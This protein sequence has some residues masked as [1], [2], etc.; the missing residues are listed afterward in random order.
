MDINFTQAQLKALSDNGITMDD[1]RN[2]VEAYR[3]Q[4]YSDADIQRGL[5]G[6]IKQIAPNVRTPVELEDYSKRTWDRRVRQMKDLGIEVPEY[7]DSVS[8]T[9][10][11][12]ETSKM[13]NDELTKRGK[14]RDRAIRNLGRAEAAVSAFGSAST[15]G[16]SDLMMAGVDAVAGTD[17][18]EESKTAK[19]EHPGYTIAGTVGGYLNPLGAATYV[20]KGV[21]YLG[22]GAKTIVTGHVAGKG[23]RILGGAA[24]MATNALGAQAV[25]QTQETAQKLAETKEFVSGDE[26]LKEYGRGSA[27]NAAIDAGFQLV[28]GVVGKIGSLAS[29]LRK[30]VDVLGG[31]ANVLKGQAAHK[32]VL[33]HGGTNEEAA[34]AFFGAVMEDL[35]TNKRK[36]FENMLAGNEEFAK[37][38]QQQMAGAG[39]VVE[40]SIKALSNPEYG[41]VSHELLKNLWGETKNEL[42]TYEIDFTKKGLERL[43][44]LDNTQKALEA[45]KEALVRAEKRV[46][47][48]A[49]LADEVRYTFN[50]LRD[51][52]VTNGSRDLERASNMVEQ[53]TLKSFE[54]SKAQADALARAEERIANKTQEAMAAGRE[55]TKSEAD[56]ILMA[57][58]RSGAKQH[59]KETM[60][61]GTDSVMDINDIKEFFAQVDEA[62]V[63]AGQA[64][65]FGAFN[66]GVNKRILDNLDEVLYK[67]N[68]AKRFGDTL[69]KMHDFGRK[70]NPEQFYELE[71][72]LNNGISAEEKAVKLS[73]FKMGF[74][75]RVTESAVAGDL[76][77]FEQARTMMTQGK[78]KQYFSTEEI[79]AYMDVV[80]PKVE[81][82][83]N[84]ESIMK[85]A[86]SATNT[87][88]DLVA[89]MIRAGVST[90]VIKSPNVFMNALTT[91]ATRISPY[92]SGT[93]RKIQQLAQNPDWKTFNRILKETTDLA[94]KRSLNQMILT[95]VQAAAQE[96]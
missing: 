90:V 68:Q 3:Q 17:L 60:A 51:N 74:L 28:G 34:A 37:F 84:I 62:S 35:P 19:K 67:T 64:E 76:K 57:E 73:A 94:E 12:N 85:A 61:N 33:K 30:S 65:A 79:G 16:L 44:G 10:R 6:T 32:L 71:S 26:A 86:Q 43:L 25:F 88:P 87:A 75:D 27:L 9:Q 4:G 11:Q 24:K 54:G 18:I 80:R 78:L 42:G 81:A 14:S 8:Y 46:M 91:L 23:G 29:K 38:T 47:A 63:K 77:T 2:S 40:D 69:G 45:R 50:E 21:D 5:W 52:L 72:A 1:L 15:L 82:A 59:F 96:D 92:G 83:R 55:F 70:Y 39:G 89:P 22:A 93:A 31:E 95:A 48:D 58:L 41:K 56:D 53:G 13:I 36:I 20:M 7:D 49:E 66:E